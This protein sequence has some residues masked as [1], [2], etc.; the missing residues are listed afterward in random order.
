MDSQGCCPHSS[1][2]LMVEQVVEE[3]QEFYY[4]ERVCRPL[5]PLSLPATTLSA[6][7]TFLTTPV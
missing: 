4:E 5:P 1:S 2:F 7:P 6:T 3:G